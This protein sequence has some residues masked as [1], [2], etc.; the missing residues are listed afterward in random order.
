MKESWEEEQQ[1]RSTA[2][3]HQPPPPAADG[4]GVV[5]VDR[6]GLPDVE[7]LAFGEAFL[8]VEQNDFVADFSGGEDVGAGGAHISCSD[9]GDL[10]AVDHDGGVG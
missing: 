8:D 4:A 2:R 1:K 3:R 9:D 10:G 7:G 5:A 6:A